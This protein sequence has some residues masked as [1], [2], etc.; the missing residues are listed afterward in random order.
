MTLPIIDLNTDYSLDALQKM[1]GCFIPIPDHIE[2]HLLAIKKASDTFFALPLET[3]CED[4]KTPDNLQGYLNQSQ[5]G[6]D[7]ERFISRGKTPKN[8]TMQ[9]VSAALDITRAYLKNDIL[10]PCLTALL[11]GLGISPDK[12]IHHFE[13]YDNT[14]SIIHYP[15]QDTQP[16]RLPA[17]ADAALLTALWAPQPGL[18]AL[19]NDKWIPTQTPPGH[20]IVQIGDGLANWVDHQLKPLVHRVI[21]EPNTPRTSI[22]SFS[23]LDNEAPYNSLITGNTITPTFQ[24]YI[25]THLQKTYKPR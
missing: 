9:A 15:P 3:K 13:D 22:A 7:I 20:V 17:H 8:P 25:K 21:V 12:Y 19:V 4:P 24:D 18:E 16:D 10:Q 11:T 5:S 23:T 6:Y 2:Q 1:G 14:L